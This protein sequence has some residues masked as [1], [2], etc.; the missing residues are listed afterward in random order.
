V[1]GCL[2]VFIVR[3][4]LRVHSLSSQIQLALKLQF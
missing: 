2:A 1:I 3:Y 4:N